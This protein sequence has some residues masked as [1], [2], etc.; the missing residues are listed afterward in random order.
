MRRVQMS[1]SRES[2]RCG[3]VQCRNWTSDKM[4]ICARVA[5]WH[6]SRRAHW[7]RSCVGLARLGTGAGLRGARRP[8]PAARPRRP[9]RR[10][11]PACRPSASSP[12]SSTLSRTT[13]SAAYA[14][15]RDAGYLES[16]RGSGSV[17]RLPHRAAP[18]PL[19][20]D[21]PPRLPRL[22]QGRRCPPCPRVA[23]RGRARRRAAA[24][25]PR[26]VRVRPD[27][28]ARA[29]AGASPTATPRAA[30]R[31]T[32][33]QIMVTIGAQHA[34][35]LLA[36][37]LLARGDR[38]LVE[39]PELPARLRGAAG[40]AARGSCRSPVTTDEGWDEAA[41]EQALQR[42][43]PTARLPHARLPQP[44]RP[45]DV[46]PSCASA[47]SPSPR[48]QGTTLIADETMAELGLD[49]QAAPRAVR[50]PHGRAVT[51]GSV[52][53]TVWG[54]LRIGW[55]RADRELIQ[56]A[57]ARC[58]SRAT[59]ARRSSSSSSC[60]SC[61]ADYDADPRRPPRLPAR[62][63]RPPRDALRRAAAGVER[64]ARRRRAH[65]LG[66]PRRPGQLA[67]RARRPQRGARDRGR[68]ALRH[69][70]RL[71]ALPAHPVQPPGRAD[72]PGGRR[73][74]RAPGSDRRRGTP[75]SS[76]HGGPRRRSV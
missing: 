76:S 61:C 51:I 17:A 67:A 31:P 45:L 72:R 44:D 2:D 8:H 5:A 63:P 16:L 13:V 38:A 40:R 24:R 42:T 64:A 12:P 68:A 55:I 11:A 53:K 70:R 10:S 28:P 57:R 60:S 47:C 4:P 27:R 37:T 21:R 32:P 18:S 26:R 14:E 52:G 59:S 75:T 36:R 19:D 20:T 48:A 56:R 54:G 1:E 50:R 15:L 23:G 46:A 30:C 49:G 65:R 58:A 74:R 41:L 29:A 73:A 22:Q 71:R 66:Q 9:H 25:L 35:G 34:I 62:G 3:I 6:R 43:S 39:S 69:R 7:P 33:T